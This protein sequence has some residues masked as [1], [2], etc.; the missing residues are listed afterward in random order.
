MYEKTS[1]YVSACRRPC[2]AST[3]R[4]STFPTYPITNQRQ[5]FLFN[6]FC[7]VFVSLL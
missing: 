3:G 4:V 7:T 1:F 2:A 6:M 5:L